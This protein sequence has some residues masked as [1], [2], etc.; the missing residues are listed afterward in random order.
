M[1]TLV[2]LNTLDVSNIKLFDLK[3]NPTSVKRETT[4]IRR[5]REALEVI[6]DH[7]SLVYNAHQNER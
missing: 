4:L 6:P 7:G 1:D 2:K 5:M 3:G